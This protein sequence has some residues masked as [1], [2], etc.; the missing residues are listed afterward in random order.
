[1]SDRIL[2]KGASLLGEG[3]ADL[4]VEDGYQATT[5]QA[6]AHLAATTGDQA[7][8]I[9]NWDPP[10]VL[11]AVDPSPATACAELY[12]GPQV[13]LVRGRVQ[14]RRVWVRLS[15]VDGCQIARWGKVPSL[16]PPGGVR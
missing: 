15:R 6:I 5:I 9:V 16:L 3:A 4:L 13:A 14:G 11:D 8:A 7:G 2:I 1:M 12:G 10:V